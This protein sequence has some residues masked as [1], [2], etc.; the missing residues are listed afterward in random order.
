MA[1]DVISFSTSSTTIL[2]LAGKTEIVGAFPANV[3]VAKVVVQGF[4]VG[5]RL[6]ALKPETDVL[7]Q[8]G[9]CCSHG[10]GRGRHGRVQL[11]GKPRQ[12]A[13]TTWHLLGR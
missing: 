13:K 10:V 1:C 8:R 5:E 12:K 11:N 2:P 4:G 7:R 6:R 3:Y 9:D